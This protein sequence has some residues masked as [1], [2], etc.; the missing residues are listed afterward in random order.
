MEFQARYPAAYEVLFQPSEATRGLPLP[1]FDVRILKNAPR[2]SVVPAG[3]N[4]D[5]R[6]A[7]ESGDAFSVTFGRRTSGDKEVD[8]S[9]TPLDLSYMRGVLLT[10]LSCI[11]RQYARIWGRRPSPP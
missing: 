9:F 4:Q 6:I 3:W 5:L 7:Q 2:A 1:S 11:M 8:Q 10:V